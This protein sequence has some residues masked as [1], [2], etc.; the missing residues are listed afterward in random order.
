MTSTNTTG[1]P[2]KKLFFKTILWIEMGQNSFSVE[3]KKIPTKY[4]TVK[5]FAQVTQ[6]TF[7]Y[8]TFKLNASIS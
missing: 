4:F 7:F 5:L 3:D 1:S 6:E 2:L 8:K